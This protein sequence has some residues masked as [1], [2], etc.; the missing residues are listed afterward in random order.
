M[1]QRH[2]AHEIL[3]SGDFK[4]LARRKNL[5]STVLT[6]IILVIYFGFIF[7]VAFRPTKLGQKVVKGIALGVPVGIPIGIAVIVFAWI[8]TGV[9]VLWANGTYDNLIARVRARVEAG[10]EQ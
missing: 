4:D 3:E 8:L 6:L 10:E 2:S 5:V 9:Y 7:L 1:A